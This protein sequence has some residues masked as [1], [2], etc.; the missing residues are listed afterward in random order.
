MSATRARVIRSLGATG[1]GLAV[2]AVMQIAG[3]PAFLHGFGVR[4]YGEW[5]VIS[6]VPAYLNLS[7]LG[8]VG[9]AGNE[10]TMRVAVGDRRS[11]QSA[12]QT[13]WAMMT[14][15]SV[16]V[17]AAV[18]SAVWLLPSE[19]LLHVVSLSHR[20]VALTLTLLAASV[21]VSMQMGMLEAGFRCAGLFPRGNVG[22]SVV[23]FASFGAAAGSAL[24]GA[25][26][27][28][29]AAAQLAA[30]VAG[31][32]ALRLVLRRDVPWLRFGVD[33][34]SSP[35]LRRL[36]SPALAFLGF[37]IGN[38]LA[39]QGM[40]LVVSAELGAVAV[41]VLSVVRTLATT[42]RQLVNVINHAVWPE[43]SRAIAADELPLARRIHVES[44]RGALGIAAGSA[45]VLVVA[46]RP[47]IHLWAGGAV[48]P[49]PA[50]LRLMLLTVLLDVAWLTSSVVLA[51]V[52]R[53]QRTALLYLASN[54]ISI[55][56]AA[57]FVPELG[58]PAVPVALMASDVLL[59][60]YV[61]RSST[62]LLRQSPRDFGRQLVT[63]RSL[64]P[65]E[66]VM[67]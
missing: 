30:L 65:G 54:V 52:N 44:L 10:M 34:I 37:P 25:G 63:F 27:V 17:S 8:Y 59:T 15:L 31:F 64:R 19:R 14:V 7:D 24:A 46:G 62:A 32:V 2:T 18:L 48:M 4:R 3:V 61:I 38:A 57:T 53:H 23:R 9:V 11:A 51:S 26:L 41:V 45:L 13:V 58:L 21:L 55:A 16:T 1:F 66:G 33:E 35:M 47:I 50:L 36:A 67:S 56:L 29:A 40:V 28:G 20:E 22:I 43:L 60:G 5:L 6:A 39:L 12:F 42:I 49:S